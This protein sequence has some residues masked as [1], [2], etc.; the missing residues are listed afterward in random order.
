VQL[1]GG[2][3]ILSGDND[4]TTQFDQRCLPINLYH[5]PRIVAELDNGEHPE[6]EYSPEDIVMPMCRS[7]QISDALL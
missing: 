6:W 4:P 2:P 1:V 5:H 3:V 7:P